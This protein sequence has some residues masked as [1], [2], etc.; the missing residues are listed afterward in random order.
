M[1][2]CTLMVVR[3]PAAGDLAGPEQPPCTEGLHQQSHEQASWALLLREA[4][5]SREGACC[6]LSGKPMPHTRSKAKELSEL[7][8]QEK[9]EPSHNPTDSKRRPSVGR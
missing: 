9:G 4:V 6:T 7:R 3:S 5:L 2:F 8:G 1:W